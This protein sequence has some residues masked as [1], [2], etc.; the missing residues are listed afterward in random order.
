MV[1]QRG[2]ESPG[3]SLRTWP[4]IKRQG[5][6]RF[7]PAWSVEESAELCHAWL[8][9]ANELA[10]PGAVASLHK[11]KGLCTSI[12]LRRGQSPWAASGPPP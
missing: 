10:E 9:Q 4:S 8:S 11:V 5:A 7:T 1:P 6:G 12:I 2:A 3:P